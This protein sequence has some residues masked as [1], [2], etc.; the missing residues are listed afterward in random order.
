MVKL[1]LSSPYRPH[2]WVNYNCPEISQ[3]TSGRKGASSRK[4]WVIYR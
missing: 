3:A 4:V 2:A 1:F